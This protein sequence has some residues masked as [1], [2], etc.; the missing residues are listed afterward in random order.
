MKVFNAEFEIYFEDISPSGIVHLEKIAEWVS[1]G[2][3]KYFR[4]TCPQHLNFVEGGVSMFT[5]NLMIKSISTSRWADQIQLEI[6][7]SKIKKISF[8]MNFKFL[9]KRSNNIIAEGVQK[10]AFINSS[11]E[12]FSPIPVDMGNVIVEYLQK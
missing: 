5:V 2:R 3:E 12:S 7:T 4:E 6:T 10:V 9:N 8:E 11:T 1:I